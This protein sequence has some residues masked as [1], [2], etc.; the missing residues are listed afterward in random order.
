[1]TKKNTKD[2]HFKRL[3]KIDESVCGFLLHPKFTGLGGHAEV[4]LFYSCMFLLLENDK[5]A[6]VEGTEV[7]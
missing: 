5:N 6:S 2:W 4:G 7:L 3:I 1:M